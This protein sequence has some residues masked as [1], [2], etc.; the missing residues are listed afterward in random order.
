MKKP[1]VDAEST[2]GMGLSWGG[3]TIVGGG[4]ERGEPPITGE[5]GIPVTGPIEDEGISREGAPM[6]EA[7]MV[8]EGEVPIIGEGWVPGFMCA[9]VSDLVRVECMSLMYV[10]LVFLFWLG[11]STW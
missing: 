1:Q 8:E 6:G 4:V 11:L 7:S 5:G 3:M 9:S 2:S 10:R